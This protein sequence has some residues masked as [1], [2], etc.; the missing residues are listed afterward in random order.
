MTGTIEIVP[1][2]PARR[3][4][5][6]ALFDGKG[7]ADNP[8]WSGCYCRC[9]HFAGTQD[10]WEAEPA[11]AN[12]AAACELIS[13]RRMQ[14]WL[15]LRDGEA[16]GWINAGPKQSFAGLSDDDVPGF[17]D[18]ETA[19][20][21]CFLIEPGSRGA[22]IA[23]RLLAAAIEGLRRKGMRRVE[24]KPAKSGIEQARNYHGPLAMYEK[25]GFEV[26]GDFSER[27]YLV[28]LGL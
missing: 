21:T 3:A 28:R 8:E 19:M 22:G 25:A 27:Q 6:L 15:A 24:A 12:R 13:E 14:G 2:T 18:S 20:V 5:W 4:D 9:Y 23:S 11:E 7:F 1:L 26:V 16:V 17:H 10:E